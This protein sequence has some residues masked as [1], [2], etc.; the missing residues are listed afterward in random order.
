MINP[1][2]GS[3]LKSKALGTDVTHL[4]GQEGPEQMGQYHQG[5]WKMPMFPRTSLFSSFNELSIATRGS[6]QLAPFCEFPQQFV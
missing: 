6:T 1:N 3:I 2:R 5:S 4:V